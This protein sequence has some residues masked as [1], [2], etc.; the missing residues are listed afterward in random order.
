MAENENLTRKRRIRGGHKASTNRTLALVKEALESSEVCAVK[1]KQYLQIL[2]EKN[3]LLKTLDAE[4]LDLLKEEG[5]ITEEIEQADIVREN[6]ESS[7][8]DI[9]E[10]L[11]TYEQ[12]ITPTR[13]RS[14]ETRAPANTRDE[15]HTPTEDPS[16]ESEIP[17]QIN[18]SSRQQPSTVTRTTEPEQNRER[19]SPQT[20]DQ[21]VRSRECKVRLPKLT[22]KKFDGD[23]TAW[24]SFW[25]S[26]ESS[27]HFNTDLTDIDKFNYLRSLLEL[28]ALESIA[29]LTLSST[30]YTEA[31][32]ILKKRF[33]NKQSQI[34]KHMEALLGLDV[35]TS[36]RDLIALRKLYDKV[37]S[38]V[39][40]LK[41]LGVTSSSYGNLL[42]SILMKKIPSD[43][44]L[45]VSRET[46]KD[47]WDLDSMMKVI[48]RELEARERAMVES[49]GG[50]RKPSR[51]PPT[52]S[53]LFTEGTPV[54]CCYCG[55][56][57]QPHQCGTVPSI[58]QRKLKLR[59]TGRCFVCLKRGHLGRVCR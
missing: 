37:E 7:I 27:I 46:I 4:I 39:R 48:E 44:S 40:C 21:I 43:I 52:A 18:S 55:G 14:P 1:L 24:T 36:S 51:E 54:A 59:Q 10:A 8:L 22:L 38:H 26:F 49:A 17:V 31:V 16:N 15:P 35:V 58:D 29:G 6:I 11:G 13:A 41:S 42:S 20:Q 30:N 25:D 57:H 50:Y 34:T 32:A 9:E 53:A 45:I 3:G 47:N 56:P 28:S 5:E 2:R 12:R 33:G 19:Q 23:V